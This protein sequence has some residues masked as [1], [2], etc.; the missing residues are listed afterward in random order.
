MSHPDAPSLPTSPSPRRSPST[1]GIPVLREGVARARQIVPEVV[2]QLTTGQTAA[3][4][5]PLAERQRNYRPKL[6]HRGRPASARRDSSS[7]PTATLPRGQPRRWPLPRR[8]RPRVPARMRRS[9]PELRPCP[10]VKRWLTA[11]TVDGGRL[12]DTYAETMTFPMLRAPM[13]RDFVP[14]LTRDNY[15]VPATGPSRPPAADQGS[16]QGVSR[17]RRV[18]EVVSVTLDTTLREAPNE[19]CR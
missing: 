1:P 14:R 15:P 2:S 7:T 5:A 18:D 6:G 19:H 8:Y 3:S 17:A 4:R 12:L 11:R 10:G 13:L 9:Q 16:H